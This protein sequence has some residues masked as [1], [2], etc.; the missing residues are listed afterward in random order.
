MCHS[1]RSWPGLLS[2]VSDLVSVFP[3][4]PGYF[5]GEGLH[6]AVVSH[7]AGNYRADA[8]SRDCRSVSAVWRAYITAFMAV[9]QSCGL[10]WTIQ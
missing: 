10:T 5:G 8:V 1:R 4:D 7:C 9:V 3:A 2:I 6:R